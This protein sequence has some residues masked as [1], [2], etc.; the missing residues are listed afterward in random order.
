MENLISPHPS[1]SKP[2]FD[3]Y[4]LKLIKSSYTT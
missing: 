2:Q 3:I 4:V 1:R